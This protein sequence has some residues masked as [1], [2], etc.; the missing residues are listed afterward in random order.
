MHHGVA[1]VDEELKEE[2]VFNHFDQ[3]LGAVEARSQGIDMDRVCLSHGQ[4]L[5]MDHCFSEEEV[6]SIIRDMPPDKAPG[7]DGF[8][9]WFSQ[10]AWPVIKR[11]VMQALEVIWSLDGRNLYLL[12]QAYMVLLCKKKDTEEI[13]DFRPISLIHSFSKLFAKLLSS[14]LAPHMHHLVL[15]NQSA[16]IHGRAIHDNFRVV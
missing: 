4:V 15:P 16:F 8:T 5:T 6:W 1:I 11:D 13:T 14:R 3:I 9:G 10:M 7:L 2:A 12:N